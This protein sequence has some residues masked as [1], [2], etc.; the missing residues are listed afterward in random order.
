MYS[1]HANGVCDPA[2]SRW[3]HTTLEQLRA[4]QH[5]FAVERGWEKL[6][7]PRNLIMALVLLPNHRKPLVTTPVQIAMVDTRSSRWHLHGAH[8]ATLSTHHIQTC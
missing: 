2:V 8:R 5:S 3:S 4:A 1:D 7:T 6:H